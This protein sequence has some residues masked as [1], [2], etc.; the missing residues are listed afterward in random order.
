M[1]CRTSLPMLA[2]C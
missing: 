2:P 1:L